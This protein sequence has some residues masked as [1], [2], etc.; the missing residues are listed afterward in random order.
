MCRVWEALYRY[1]VM[2]SQKAD[3]VVRSMSILIPSSYQNSYHL[4]LRLSE[5]RLVLLLGLDE[6]LLEAVGV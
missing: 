5:Q 6:G 2:L 3:A 1:D 4:L